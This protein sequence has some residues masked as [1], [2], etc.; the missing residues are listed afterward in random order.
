MQFPEFLNSSPVQAFTVFLILGLAIGSFVNVVT[1]R[2]PIMLNRQ[3]QIE[4]R[5]FLGLLRDPHD[6][7]GRPFNLVRPWSHCPNCKRRIKPWEMIPV[8]GYLLLLGKCAGCRQRI[9]LRYP[10]VEL[11]CG[12]LAG[13]LVLIYGAGWL[14]LA[15]LLFCYMLIALAIIDAENQLLPDIITLPLL[16]LGLLLNALFP[17][18]LGTG[19]ADA[20]IGA[21]AAYLLLGGFHYAYRI[22]TGKE[23]MAHGDFKLLAALCAWL[24]WVA[25]PFIVLISSVIGAVW[26]LALVKIR[27]RS[28]SQPLAFGPFLAIAG[29]TVLLAGPERMAGWLG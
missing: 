7:E 20:I 25:L 28:W 19:P 10:I 29:F 13:L 17:D 8:F 12:L 16:W 23:G 14:T 24:G 6:A 11:A 26:G 22:L 18:L 1:Y 9:S 15:L 5:H 4:T 2:L 27:G 21:A 3:W